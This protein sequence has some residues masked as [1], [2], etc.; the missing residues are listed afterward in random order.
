MIFDPNQRQNNRSAR[1]SMAL[2]RMT[3]AIKK[4][5][6]LESDAAG[7]TPIQIQALLFCLHTRSDAATVGNFAHAIGT[8][9]VTAVKVING[10]VQKE[11]I[12]KAAKLEDRRVTLLQLTSEGQ[13]AAAKLEQWGQSLEDL[14]LTI[15]EETLASLEL[16]LGSVIAAMQ[17]EGHVV[18]AEPCLGCIHF[19][20]NAREG[21]EPH[22]CGLVQ[23]HLSNEA[24]LKECPEHTSSEGV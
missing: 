22:Y 10:L 2:F 15:P 9:H 8:T 23:K 6:Q 5:T 20:P 3:Q 14:L 1:I 4:M 18:V 17:Q 24:S 7:F 13:L 16:G 11:L 19:H 21:S 12:N